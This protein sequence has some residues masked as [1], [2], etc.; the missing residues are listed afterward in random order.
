LNLTKKHTLPI[1]LAALLTGGSVLPA[2]AQNPPAGASK[3]T[4]AQ[5]AAP[6][7]AEQKKVPPDTVVLQIGD[8]KITA[9][10]FS[11]FLSAVQADPVT[12]EDPSF[13][14]QL[15]EGLI[16]VRLLAREARK[17]GLDKV[18]KTKSLLSLAQDQVLAQA[19]A[20]QLVTDDALRAKFNEK[21]LV[22]AR[23]ILI[24]TQANGPDGKPL[25][26]EGARKKANDLRA[27]IEKGEDFAALAKSDSDD[28]GSKDIGGVYT[29]PRG[30]MVKEFEDA[31]FGLKEG[32]LSQPVKTKFGYHL[33]QRVPPDLAKLRPQLLNEVAPKKMDELLADLKKNATVNLNPDFFGPAP[34]PAAAAPAPAATGAPG[35]T[36][37]PVDK[38]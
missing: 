34:A 6:A 21:G 7:A 1:L 18:D 13:R 11:N 31:A 8:E 16:R 10:E 5:P 3:P 33:I 4:A 28:P 14:R 19:V 25:T 26:E 23:H 27:R 35:T 30:Q 2:S 12:A 22:T 20:D 29:F 24:S 9:G 32:E 15:A 38:K 17:R 36:P 37:A